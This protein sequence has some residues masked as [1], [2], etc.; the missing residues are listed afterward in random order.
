ML[1]SYYSLLATLKSI[2]YFH[3]LTVRDSNP[4]GANC[5]PIIRL[6]RLLVMVIHSSVFGRL[7]FSLLC[8]KY[9]SYRNLRPFKDHSDHTEWS[10]TWAFLQCL[11]ATSYFGVFISFPVS[12]DRSIKFVIVVPGL[13]VRPRQAVAVQ[14]AGTNTAKPFFAVTFTQSR[15]RSQR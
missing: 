3:C 10:E 1:L 8:W 6:V 13:A 11:N 15:L 2:I 12:S 4:R 5:G 7:Q 14:A 9:L